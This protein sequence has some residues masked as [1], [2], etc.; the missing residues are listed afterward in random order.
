M[1]FIKQVYV[2]VFMC[3]YVK[4]G[5]CQDIEITCIAICGMK[6][7]VLIDVKSRHDNIHIPK[8]MRGKSSQFYYSIE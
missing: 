8:T 1:T 7:P 2:H 5:K 6:V 3:V 4:Y